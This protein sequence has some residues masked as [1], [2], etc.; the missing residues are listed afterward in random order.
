MWN[1]T[2]HR[3]GR[4]SERELRA[5]TIRSPAVLRTLAKALLVPSSRS[6]RPGRLRHDSRPS[7]P[8][9]RM[10]RGPTK[11]SHGMC[12]HREERGIDRIR[13]SLIFL[14]ESCDEMPE[15]G[16]VAHRVRVEK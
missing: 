5:K 6:C 10:C 15:A 1:G 16:F 9:G 3:P 13:E 2:Q 11:E 12:R 4:L 8:S 14:R 7:A